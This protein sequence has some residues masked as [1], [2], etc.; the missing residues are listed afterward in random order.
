MPVMA[1]GSER[2]DAPSALGRDA[3]GL[4]TERVCDALDHFL[5][6]LAGCERAPEQVRLLLESARTA[7]EADVVYWYPLTPGEPLE[8]VG[9]C[10]LSPD[11]YRYIAQR[12]L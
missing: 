2:T 12:L 3:R 6:Q 4:T 5:R 11:W 7:L 1:A 8:I 9:D 10:G